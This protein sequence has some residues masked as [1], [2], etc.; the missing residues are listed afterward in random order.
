MKLI[1]H[2]T[3][4]ILFYFKADTTT[5]TFTTS[6]PSATVELGNFNT[7]E[8]VLQIYQA[9]FFGLVVNANSNDPFLIPCS[10]YV[11]VCDIF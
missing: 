6:S 11:K 3:N 2:E 7:F 4:F 1:K 8:V 9:R 10:I 5:S